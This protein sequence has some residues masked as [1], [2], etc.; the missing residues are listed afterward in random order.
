MLLAAAESFAAPARLNLCVLE[1]DPRACRFYATRGWTEGVF[2]PMYG[3]VAQ[4][5]H[6]H[7]NVLAREHRGTA[8]Q[9]ARTKTHILRDPPSDELGGHELLGRRT[10]E[11]H[12]TE[13]CGIQ[14][15]STTESKHYRKQALQK[16]STTEHLPYMEGTP[17]RK[18]RTSTSA[19]G[20]IGCD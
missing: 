19:A 2:Y 9:C 5:L 17:M 1:K 3:H 15:A 13:P 11:V 6:K 12:C 16:A 14:K 10:P 4:H 8:A 18:A 7:I 20:W